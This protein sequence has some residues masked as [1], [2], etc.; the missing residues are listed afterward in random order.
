MKKFNLLF[1]M[2]MALVLTGYS[3][4]TVLISTPTALPTPA[5]ANLPVSFTS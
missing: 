1:S 5:G 3:Q 2:M 4:N